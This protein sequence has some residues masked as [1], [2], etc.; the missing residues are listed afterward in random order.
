MIFNEISNAVFR[1]DLRCAGAKIDGVFKHPPAGGGKSRGP[2][3]RGIYVPMHC[4]VLIFVVASEL[5]VSA[6]AL[7]DGAARLVTLPPLDRYSRR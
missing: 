6:A 1:F 2:S 4:P 3:G 5:C 7:D